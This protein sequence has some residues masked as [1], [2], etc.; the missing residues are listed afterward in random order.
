ML[1]TER[2]ECIQAGWVVCDW[3]A[4]DIV[5]D[6]GRWGRLKVLGLDPAGTCK[7]K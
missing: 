7:P 2:H 1:K 4:E 3:R 5:D 6:A